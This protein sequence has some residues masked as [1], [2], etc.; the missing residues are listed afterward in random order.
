[1][2][3]GEYARH[4]GCS[5]QAVGRALR[6][7]R[8]TATAEG[9]IDPVAA[10]AQW[11]ARSRPRVRVGASRPAAVAAPPADDRVSY[12]EA[13]RRQAVADALM[14]ER[15]ERVQ[16]GELVPV[17]AVRQALA[18]RLS[19]ARQALTDMSARLSPVLAAES[20]PA[21][22]GRLLDDDVARALEAIT[23]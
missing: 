9:L 23:Y 11:A 8:I 13:R 18:A 12:D 21:V 2:T 6:E 19:S 15:A 4:R 22:I 5:R 3:P 20:D 14:A 10:D 17:A 16:R 7:G 1:M